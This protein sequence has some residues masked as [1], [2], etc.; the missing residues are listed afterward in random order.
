MWQQQQ[1]QDKRD[2]PATT[3][4]TTTHGDNVLLY[5]HLVHAAYV[6][7]QALPSCS[8]PQTNTRRE[9][10]AKRNHNLF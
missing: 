3:P 10:S 7:T 1:Q 6:R 8:A 5:N 4:L 9:Q 2:P